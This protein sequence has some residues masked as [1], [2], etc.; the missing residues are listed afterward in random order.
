MI[1]SKRAWETYPPTYRDR[2]INT[3]AHWIRA[4]ESGSIIGLAG[5]GKSNLLG[6]LSHRSEAITAKF[7]D[8]SCKLALVLV[9]LNNLPANDPATLY[10]VILRSLYEARRQLEPMEPGLLSLLE[11]LY[12]KVE[13][14]TDPFVSQSALRE[15]I[16]FCQEK[17][18]RLVLVFD[19]FEQFCQ[20]APTSLLDNLRGLRDTFKTTLSYLFGLRQEVG[21]LRD[22]LELGELYEIVDT[23]VCWVG[24]MERDDARWVIGQIETATGQTFEPAQV[25]RLIDLTGS[26]PALLRAAGLWLSQ[27]S[28]VPDLASWDEHLLAEP[29]IQ[30]RLRDL[31]SGL[32]GEEEAVLSILQMARALKSAK[33]RQESL[34]QIEVKYRSALARLQSKHLCY[35]TEAGWQFFSPLFARFVT[36]MEGISAGKIRHDL[37][38]DRFFQGEKEL[39]NLSERD[40]RLLRHFLTHPWVAHSLDDLIE[41]AW[42]EDDSSGISNEAVQQAIRHLRK[43]IEPNPARPCYLVTEPRSGYRFFPEGAPHG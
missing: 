26:Y 5:A 2:E 13:D 9:D 38:T 43:Q 35:L 8:P 39:T 21:Y 10:R 34:R 14:K 28:P 18:V 30:N 22:P 25:D 27:V 33:E 11:I 37:A 42:P 24:S 40:G 32:T 17:R 29:S 16:F 7:V 15:A 41:A 1:V 36:R 23:H 12:R 19:P 6:F 4:G 31:R 3:L 20:T